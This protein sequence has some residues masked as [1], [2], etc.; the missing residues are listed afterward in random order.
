[1]TLFNSVSFIGG[2]GGPHC[3][4]LRWNDLMTGK[5]GVDC[6]PN[7]EPGFIQLAEGVVMWSDVC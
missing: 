4:Q 6:Y 3:L 5:A 7:F 2:G 1:M